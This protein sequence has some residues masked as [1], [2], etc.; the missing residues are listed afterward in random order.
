MPGNHLA[1]GVVSR[2]SISRLDVNGRQ[3]STGRI[4]LLS[5][6]GA[7]TTEEWCSDSSA[8][9]CNPLS[10][11]GRAVSDPAV[12]H[13]A[14]V[15]VNGA[16]AGKS[17]LDWIAR[18]SPEYD[19][20][21]DTRLAPLGLSEKQVQA[22]WVQ[23]TD[24]APT[25]SLPAPAA[26]AYLLRDRLSDVMRS[27]KARYPNLALVFVSSR[28]Y[29]GYSRNPFLA[30]PFSY[31]SAFAVKWLIQAHLSDTAPWIGWGPYFWSEGAK[32]NSDGLT[33]SPADFKSDGANLSEA[34]QSKAGQLLLEFFKRS[35]LTSCWFLAAQPCATH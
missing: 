12:N 15:I 5:I 4:V 17:A 35:E 6:G 25:V 23:I 19:R 29:G 8:P 22:V 26:D 3:S 34:G 13:E 16:M 28:L 21:R 7:N 1:D 20:I 11:S 2:G 31:E 18:T 33:W 27:L 9:P 10:F 30:E 32:P 24:S 14:L